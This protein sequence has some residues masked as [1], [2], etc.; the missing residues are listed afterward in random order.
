MWRKCIFR[1]RISEKEGKISI[2]IEK[3]LFPNV[4]IQLTMPHCD[5]QGC[6]VKEKME[7]ELWAS[8]FFGRL[9]EKKFIKR[10]N[11]FFRHKHGVID[12]DLELLQKFPFT[13]GLKILVAGSNGLIGSELV[14]LLKFFGHDVHK[15]VRKKSG[16][17][18]EIIWDPETGEV[19]R[20]GIEG[21]DVVVNLAGRGLGDKRWTKQE[22]ARLKSSRVQLTERLVHV[23][24][25][26]ENPP[27]TLI[28]A[29]AIGFYGDSGDKIVDESIEFCGRGFLAN[30][31]SEWE[32]ASQ[33]IASRGT[34]VVNPRFSMVLSPAGGALRKMTAFYKKGFGSILGRGGQYVSWVAIDDA[35]AALYHLIMTPSISGPVD[36]ASPHPTTNSEMSHKIAHFFKKGL[37]PALTPGV[38]R[39]IFGQLGEEVLLSSIR[40]ESKKLRESGFNFR[41]PS[42]EVALKHLLP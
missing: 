21:F 12:Y 13:N 14:E 8:W 38:V 5:N 9:R 26:L 17:G 23:L 24:G 31:A 33:W 20:S 34:R 2:Y 16:Y 7:Y 22:K 19:D 28:N 4:K 32:V 10:A 40:S 37:G 41:Y 1:Y 30:L 36:I 11:Y 29:S 6:E 15:L 25:G 42:L 27:K 39:L 35:V 18:R 3:G